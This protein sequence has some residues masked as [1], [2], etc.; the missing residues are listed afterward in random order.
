ME[1]AEGGAANVESGSSRDPVQGVSEFDCNQV[2]V[3]K[4]RVLRTLLGLVQ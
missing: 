3:V 2:R 1:E 4:T